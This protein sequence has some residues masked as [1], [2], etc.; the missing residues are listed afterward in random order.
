MPLLDHAELPPGSRRTWEGFHY[1]W[2]GKI[3]DAVSPHLP[4]RYFL[5]AYFHSGARFQ[6]DIAALEQDTEERQQGNGGGAGTALATYAPPAPPLDEEAEFG[7]LDVAELQIYSDDGEQALVA[8]IELVSPSNKDRPAS[9]DAFAGKCL[10]YLREGVSVL[11]VDVITERQANFHRLIAERLSLS[12]A[13]R[14]AV[15]SDLYA[16]SYRTTGIGTTLRL[17]AWPVAL[18]I[19]S[20]LPTM[21]LWLSPFLAVPVDLE[22]SYLA[23]CG[24]MRIPVTSAR[25][26]PASPASTR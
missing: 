7:T 14:G 24:L 23:T 16:V 2:G 25:T 17:Q 20:L 13:A 4:P 22:T 18:T 3:A 10:S 19:G 5:E 9:R 8:V 11:V 6:T 1:Y 26:A 21:P 12:G 15:T